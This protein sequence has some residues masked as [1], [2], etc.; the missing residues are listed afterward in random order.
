MQK[1]L[2]SGTWGEKKF[3]NNVKWSKMV[4]WMWL[5]IAGKLGDFYPVNVCKIDWVGGIDIR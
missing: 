4:R 1:S 3:V 5:E 2:H